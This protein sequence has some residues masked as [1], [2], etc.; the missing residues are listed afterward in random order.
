[1]KIT[2]QKILDNVNIFSRGAPTQ[3]NAMTKKTPK[4]ARPPIVYIKDAKM[5]ICVHA[6]VEMF[7]GFGE[8]ARSRVGTDPTTTQT[9]YGSQDNDAGRP[10]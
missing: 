5:H 6:C 3:E 10:T 4:A 9:T 7:I 8:N 1:M 2:F